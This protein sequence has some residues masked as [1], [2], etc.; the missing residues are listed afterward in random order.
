MTAWPERIG[1]AA[2]PVKYQIVHYPGH[3]PGQDVIMF[4]TENIN[5]Q[6][7]RCPRE[8]ANPDL[9]EIVVDDVPDQKG[10]PER[11]FHAWD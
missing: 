7:E 1:H 2:G 11:L 8:C 5:S 9:F 10:A 3:H 4:M 6:Q